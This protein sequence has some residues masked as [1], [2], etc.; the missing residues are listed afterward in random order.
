MKN[1]DNNVQNCHS[2]EEQE[3][4]TDPTIDADFYD[5]NQHQSHDEGVDQAKYFCEG[6]L[7]VRVFVESTENCVKDDWPDDEG[8]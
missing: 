2:N 8:V 3:S 5:E 1:S 7:D 4:R 6:E